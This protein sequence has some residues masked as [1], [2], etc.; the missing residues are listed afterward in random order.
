M[1]LVARHQGLRERA[2]VYVHTQVQAFVAAAPPLLVRYGLAIWNARV[3]LPFLKAVVC[4]WPGIWTTI[5]HSATLLK[6]PT[7]LSHILLVF[8]VYRCPRHR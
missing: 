6:D 3:V 7:S 5:D 8:W 4:I 2:R 1:A